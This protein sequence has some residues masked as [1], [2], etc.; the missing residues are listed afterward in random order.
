MAEEVTKLVTE[1][2]SGYLEDPQEAARELARLDGLCRSAAEHITNADKEY[3]KLYDLI[4]YR[5]SDPFRVLNRI[6]VNEHVEKKKVKSKKTGAEYELSYLSWAWAWQTLM[7][8]YPDSYTEIERPEN[9]LPYWTDNKT[10]WVDVSVTVVW[11]DGKHAQPQ[12]RTRSEVFPIMDNS[13]QSITLDRLTSFDVNKALQRAWTKC[14]ARHG[15]G[16]YIYAGEDLPAEEAEEQKSE[17]KKKAEKKKPSKQQNTQQSN[18]QTQKPTSNDTSQMAVEL[19]QLRRDLTN[20]GVNIHLDG[21][22]NYVKTTAQVN[23]IDP[24]MLLSDLA[25]MSRVIQVMRAIKAKKEKEQE[26]PKE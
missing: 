21:F 22:V 13:N 11:E 4:K 23:T 20:M 24:G 15:L 8:L 14:I 7:E 2:E 10:C 26:K 6:N 3:Q 1:L 25:A 5:E 19:N 9:G 18:T 17:E 16:F 12:K